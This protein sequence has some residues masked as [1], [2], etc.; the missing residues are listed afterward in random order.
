MKNKNLLLSLLTAVLS[1]VLIVPI[2]I[3]VFGYTWSLGDS[4]ISEGAYGIFADYS[5]IS[6]LYSDFSATWS[7]VFDICL[8]VGLVLG[9]LY[10]VAVVLELL[11]VKVNVSGIKKVVGFAFILVFVVALVVGIVFVSVNHYKGQYINHELN[12]VPQAGFYIALATM[13]V[14]GVL[15]I[16]TA[17]KVKKGKKKR[18]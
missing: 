7:V 13:L 2:F 18:K 15:A 9:A 8:I 5:A 16:L 6:N 11:K 10:V 12:I 1:L 14:S 4:V 3:N 17:K